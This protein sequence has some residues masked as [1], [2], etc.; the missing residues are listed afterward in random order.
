MTARL[1]YVSSATG[2]AHDKLGYTLVGGCEL[3]TL[4][5]LAPNGTRCR[6]RDAAKRELV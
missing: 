3:A 2:P 5:P 6:G 1:L 4:N